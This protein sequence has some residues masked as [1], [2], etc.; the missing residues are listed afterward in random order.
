MKKLYKS[1]TD[2]VLSGVIGGIGEYFNIDPTILRLLFILIAILTALMIATAA[3]Y[4]KVYPHL[5]EDYPK[6][7]A[8]ALERAVELFPGILEPKSSWWINGKGQA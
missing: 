5:I 1:D 6:F 3:V 7:S 8:A 4:K 2:K